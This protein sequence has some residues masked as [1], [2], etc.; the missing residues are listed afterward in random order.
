MIGCVVPTSRPKQQ[1]RP[2]S[3]ENDQSSP[4][5]VISVNQ[6]KCRILPIQSVLCAVTMWPRKPSYIPR[7]RSMHSRVVRITTT[8]HP[9]QYVKMSFRKKNLTLHLLLLIL[10]MQLLLHLRLWIHGG[11][12][13]GLRLKH[14]QLN[15]N[16]IRLHKLHNVQSDE[17]KTHLS[18]FLKSKL[19]YFPMI[20]RTNIAIATN[21]QQMWILIWLVH[22]MMWWYSGDTKQ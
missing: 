8:R 12:G 11:S 16:W 2:A 10:L 1:S 14:D 22:N 4:K 5:D 17:H 20:G 9:L 7:K 15:Y 3:V 6:V 21:M 13:R 19:S 18:T